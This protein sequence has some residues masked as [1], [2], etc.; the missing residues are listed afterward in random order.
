MCDINDINGIGMPLQGFGTFLSSPEEAFR[1]VPH[2]LKLGYRHIDTAEAYGNEEG[3][4]RA[5][6]ES[7]VARHKMFVTTKLWPGYAAW[8]QPE[9]THETTLSSFHDSRKK[10]GLE[11]IDLYLIHAP[12]S[13]KHRLDQWKAII[14]LQQ[15]GYVKY[16]GV[17]NYGVKHLEEIE[18]AGL[19]LPAVNQLELHPLSTQ[20]KAMTFMKEHSILPIAYSSLA[21]LSTWRTAEGQG[22]KLSQSKKHG[23]QLVI[24][25]M[26]EELG[27]SGAQLL[28]RWALQHRFCI[29]P[30]STKMERI[31]AN[32][33]LYSFQITD[34]NMKI[35]DSLD[36]NMAMAWNAWGADFGLPNFNPVEDAE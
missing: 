15:L 32:L 35:L 22:G 29:L 5:I 4:G 21:P 14:E 9:K 36:D 10:L 2:A 13:K 1:A 6:A 11:Y 30:K 19:P 26:A 20:Q 24:K 7:G 8:G 25:K 34:D 33:E 23:K 12:L 27:V 17:S 28:L 3:V 18:E 31:Q 16:I